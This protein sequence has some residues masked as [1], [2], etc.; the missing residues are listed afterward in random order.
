[1]K[2]N[3]L[4]PI[5]P[6]HEPVLVRGEGSYVYDEE[7]KKLL[8]LNSGQFCTV[9]GHSNKDLIKEITRIS[10]T[11]VH[12][13]SGM[14]SEEVVEV[15]KKIHEI[16]GNMEAYS[17]L[18]STGAE[19][20]EFALRYAKHLKGRNGIV[21]FQKGY[22][23]LTLGTQSVTFGGVYAAPEVSHIFSVPIPDTFAEKEEVDNCL[24]VLEKTLA[25]HGKEIAGVLM[26]PIV[27]VGGMIFPVKEYFTEVRR[28]CDEYD[29]LL[30]LDECQ[31]GFG[32]TGSWF[33]Y[34]QLGIVPDMVACAK[35]IG[36][37]YPV[38]LVM[39]RNGLVP[40]EGMTMTHYSSH[41]NDGFA[42]AI[43]NFGI[44]YIKEHNLLERATEIGIYFLE[45][46]K[47]LEKTCP[48]YTKARGHGL[49]LGLDLQLKGVDNYR[50][51][52]QELTEKST[53]E[54]VLLQ[55]TNGGQI[56]RFLPDYLIQKEDIDFCVEV[57]K[58]AA[59]GV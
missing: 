6:F 18:L 46:L 45:K 56:L 50:P 5:V 10:E 11:L 12:T 27:S 8:D 9:L 22:H 39:F 47:E 55:G 3:Y 49:M 44:Q 35:G 37:G 30:I 48:V 7:G 25:E 42:A 29:V 14:I 20:V 15:S 31:T 32:R 58:K 54:G 24:A 4:I 17:I 57:L 2:E 51:V 52:Y 26:E 38:S 23:G 43:V 53:K 59:P 13:S 19:S 34:E 40:K 28:L 36:L 33:Y 21:C 1:M 16:S 41:Q